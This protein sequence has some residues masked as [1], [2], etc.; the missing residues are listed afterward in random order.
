MILDPL[1][2]EVEKPV[3]YRFELGDDWYHQVGVAAVAEAEPKMRCPRVTGRVGGS[4]S[5]YVDEGDDHG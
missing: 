5:Q 3:G 1:G 2:L 4:P